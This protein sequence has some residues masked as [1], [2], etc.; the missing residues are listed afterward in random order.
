MSEDFNLP[1]KERVRV[2]ELGRLLRAKREREGISLEQSAKLSGVSSATLS[3][4]ERNTTDKKPTPDTRTLERVANW[5]GVSISTGADEN[6]PPPEKL[7][8]PEK[9]EIHLRADS[10]LK[11]EHAE[12]IA[13]LFRQIYDTYTTSKPDL[14]ESNDD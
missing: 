1:K 10:N 13:K 5:L 12:I 7:T 3:R 2:E 8:V 11:G 6:S 9:V 14:E 4:L